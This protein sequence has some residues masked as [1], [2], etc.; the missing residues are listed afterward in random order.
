MKKVQRNKERGEEKE[1]QGD[2]FELWLAAVVVF[3]L[4][5]HVS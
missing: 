5:D 2:D 4:N 3:I 1:K